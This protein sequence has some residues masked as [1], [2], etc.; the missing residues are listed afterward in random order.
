MRVERLSALRRA[1]PQAP[2][3][4]ALKPAEAF[5]QHALLPAMD[6]GSPQRSQSHFLLINRAFSFC[7]TVF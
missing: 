7:Q 1:G 6:T 4:S 2:S 5:T 3:L